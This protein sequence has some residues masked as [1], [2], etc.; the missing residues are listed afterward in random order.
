[1]IAVVLHRGLSESGILCNGVLN[2]VPYTTA[3]TSARSFDYYWRWDDDPDMRPEY[4]GTKEVG[5]ALNVP[6]NSQGRDIRLFQIA[7]TSAGS[8]DPL[9]A[10][11]RQFVIRAIDAEVVTYL[12]DTV[13]YGGDRVIY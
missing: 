2:G 3:R 5:I 8:S 11:A 13:L 6:F 7:R 4:L 9:I 12:G 10:E 1:M